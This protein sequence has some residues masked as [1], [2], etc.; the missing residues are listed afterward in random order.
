MANHILRIE[1]RSEGEEYFVN[2]LIPIAK[3]EVKVRLGKIFGFSWNEYEITHDDF[4]RIKEYINKKD[5]G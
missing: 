5:Q 2:E 4:I 3:D 1:P